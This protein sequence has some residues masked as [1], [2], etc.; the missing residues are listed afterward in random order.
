MKC[1]QLHSG[2]L[3]WCGQG[4]TEQDNPTSSVFVCSV[5]VGPVGTL[6]TVHNGNADPTE[7]NLSQKL[8]T[9]G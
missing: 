8:T 9:V 2:S 7:D 5:G 3:S 4:R 1:G 6:C